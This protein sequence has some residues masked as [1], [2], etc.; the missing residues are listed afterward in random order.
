[1]V[2][3]RTTPTGIPIRLCTV[4]GKDHPIT[5]RHCGKCGA[6]SIFIGEDGVCIHCKGRDGVR[7]G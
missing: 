2:D 1:M 7:R 6:A 3:V 4:C 5:R